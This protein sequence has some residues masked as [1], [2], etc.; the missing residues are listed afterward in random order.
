MCIF[1]SIDVDIVKI[2]FLW[3]L[4]W[5]ESTRPKSLDYQGIG[6]ITCKPDKDV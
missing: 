1:I 2:L 6:R 4:A 5:L 3:V